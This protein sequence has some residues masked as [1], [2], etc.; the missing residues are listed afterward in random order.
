MGERIVKGFTVGY[1]LALSQFVMTW[2]LAGLY[3][4]RANEV[5]DPIRA[6]IVKSAGATGTPETRGVRGRI[7]RFGRRGQGGDA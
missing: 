1:A 5:L 3:L 2:V 6:R 7:R 4:K